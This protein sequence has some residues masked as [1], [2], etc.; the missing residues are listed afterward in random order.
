MF[1]WLW[2]FWEKGR[3]LCI[4]CCCLFDMREYKWGKEVVERWR[5]RHRWAG[6]P[7]PVVWRWVRG[8]GVCEGHERCFFLCFAGF[9][10]REGKR[11]LF[12]FLFSP[13]HKGHLS[14]HGWMRFFYFENPNALS[15]L[16]YF[17][18]FSILFYVLFT[19]HYY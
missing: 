10:W 15:F 3:G 8:R 6:R 11:Y 16:A 14:K 19:Y 4:L 5:V 18:Y 9:K 12:F 2:K 17:F 1:V 13:L 7:P